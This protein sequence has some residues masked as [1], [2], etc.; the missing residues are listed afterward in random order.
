MADRESTDTDIVSSRNEQFSEKI[1]TKIWLE[2]SVDQNAYLA[3]N[4]YCYGYDI[5][6]LTNGACY[7]DVLY[8]LFR[9][10]LPDDAE[11]E[12]FNALLIAFIN[13]GPRDHGSRAA[14]QAA[15]GKTDSLHILPIALTIFAGEHNGAIHLVETMKFMVRLPK[16]SA[17]E[18]L[19]DV[20]LNDVPESIGFGKRYG[21]CDEQSYDLLRMFSQMQG[22]GSCLKSLQ[23][24]ADELISRHDVGILPHGII[25]AVFADLGFLPRQ[26]PPLLQLISAPGILAHGLE[27]VGKPRSHVPFLADEFY[28]ILGENDD[29]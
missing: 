7:S 11:G 13:P 12:L 29:V 8:L 25:A 18:R 10:E 3:K 27:F 2:E 15:I 24:L 6:E 16:K 21:G 23:E 19:E 26:A 17:G 20:L 9:G 22:A 5:R 14:I 28:E 1:K 4:S